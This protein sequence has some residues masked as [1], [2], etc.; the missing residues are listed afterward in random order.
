MTLRRRAS[1]TDASPATVTVNGVARGYKPQQI[2]GNVREGDMQVSILNDEITAAS[3][4]GPPLPR[5]EIVIDGNLWRVEGCE[6]LYEGTLC[7]GHR[8]QVRGGS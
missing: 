4:P 2:A 6:T 1:A 7:I 5:D 3:W 8:L